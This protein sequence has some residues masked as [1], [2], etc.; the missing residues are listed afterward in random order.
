ML[1]KAFSKVDVLDEI[2]SKTNY[3]YTFVY[4]GSL[5]GTPK[6]RNLSSTRSRLEASVKVLSF[7]NH[8]TQKLHHENI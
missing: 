4:L 6:N 7:A 1:Q 8:L 3:L 5:K 2:P